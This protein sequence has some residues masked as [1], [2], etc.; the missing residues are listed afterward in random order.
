MH[1]DEREDVAQ[2][3][4]EAVKAMVDNQGG[5]DGRGK[6]RRDPGFLKVLD[7]VG[8]DPG[9]FLK[10]LIEAQQAG[11]RVD[12]PPGQVH[13]FK[14]LMMPALV[15]VGAITARTREL[16]DAEKIPIFEDASV[17]EAMESAAT[18]VIEFEV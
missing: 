10:S 11:I 14:D 8:I 16:Y 17:L 4:F 2:F 9:D 5:V 7:T 6:R 13:S 18:G 3:A 12:R 1:P 15:R